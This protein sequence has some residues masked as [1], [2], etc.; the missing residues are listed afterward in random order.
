MILRQVFL[1]VSEGFIDGAGARGSGSG[2]GKLICVANI[3]EEEG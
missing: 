1:R 2:R 3:L